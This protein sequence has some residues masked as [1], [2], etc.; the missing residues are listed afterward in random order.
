MEAEAQEIAH[1]KTAYISV[2]AVVSAFSVVMLH[3]N[4]VFWSHPAGRLWITA[5]IIESTFYFA[6]PVFFM[7][8]GCTLIDYRARYSTMTFFCKRIRKTLIPFL[9][10]S[11]FAYVYCSATA[12]S[13]DLNP[14]CVLIKIFNYK[15]F[16]IYWFFI[17]LFSIYMCIPVLNRISDKDRIFPYMLV[18]AFVFNSINP[19]LNNHGVHVVPQT[20]N[21]PI[22]A[23][24]LIYPV[25]GYTLHNAYIGKPFRRIIY[26]VGIASLVVHF[27]T[28]LNS[29]AGGHIVT[30]FKDY[31]CFATILYATA[32]FVFFKYNS[33]KILNNF[34]LYALVNYIKPTTLGIYLT[35]IYVYKISTHMLGVLTSS[36]IFRTAGA[37]VCFFALAV[38]IRVIQK[39]KVGRVLLPL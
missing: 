3:F 14:L 13:F 7:I 21:F 38:I 36:W 9:I 17:P 22:C 5:N 33:H 37:L 30:T 19:W 8:S 4:G 32:V 28:T 25:L 26:I 34:K 12:H 39:T 24:Y 15:Y 31:L 6:V 23:G 2:L 10:W 1:T 20:M 16:Y 18:L 27:A 11:M 35:H 29:N